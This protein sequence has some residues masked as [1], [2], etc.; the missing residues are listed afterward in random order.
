MA[1]TR[2]TRGPRPR[3]RAAAAPPADAEASRAPWSPRSPVFVGLSAIALGLPLAVL[4]AAAGAYDDPK[5][6]AL[7]L[8]VAATGLAWLARRPAALARESGNEGRSTRLLQWTVVAY[9]AWSLITTATSVAPG[10]S[11]LGSFGRGMGL[12]V[13]GSA[14]LLFFLVRSECRTPDAI[15]RLIDMALLGS[16][17]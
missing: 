10:Q 13:V 12:L 8:L 17:P 9:L 4:A 15:R 16:V 2:T 5:A 7:P 1:G 14:A 11:V 3:A 6:W